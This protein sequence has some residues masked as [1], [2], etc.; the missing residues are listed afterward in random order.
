VPAP[1]KQYASLILWHDDAQRVAAEGS[2]ERQEARVGHVCTLVAPLDHF[3]VAED[4]HQKY[5]LRQ[6]RVQAAEVLSRFETEAAFRDSTAAARINGYVGGYGTCEEL[7]AEIERFSLSERAA[8]AL[9]RM[10][11]GTRRPVV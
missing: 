6:D 9:V 5:Y 4:Y 3:S 7:T 2:L 10:L 11:C 1:S 8:D